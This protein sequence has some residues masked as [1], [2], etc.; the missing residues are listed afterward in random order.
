[1]RTRVLKRTDET[2]AA[3]ISV[4]HIQAFAHG[5]VEL[6]R[7]YH[8][9]CCFSFFSPFPFIYAPHIPHSMHIREG[10]YMEIGVGTFFFPFGLGRNSLIPHRMHGCIWE[11]LGEGNEQR[12]RMTSTTNDH[13]RL[14]N[15]KW[16]ILS[17]HERIR[18]GWMMIAFFFSFLLFNS[19]Y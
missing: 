18:D 8:L 4:T 10:Y 9:C 12:R 19:V 3:Y 7:W 1:M 16:M 2:S 5:L 14:L 13:C 6:L 11:G 17:S 15:Q